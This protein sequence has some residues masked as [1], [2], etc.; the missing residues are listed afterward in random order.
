V[1]VRSGDGNHAFVLQDGAT[2]TD[3]AQNF[4]GL[5]AQHG[6]APVSIQIALGSDT[7]R[8]KLP[9]HRDQHAL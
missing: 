1:I 9:E 8:V 4:D 6:A 3:L 7:S 5:E 2:L